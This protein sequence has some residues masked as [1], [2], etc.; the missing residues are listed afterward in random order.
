M[1]PLSFGDTLSP[2]PG[3][4]SV[5]YGRA[6]L[7]VSSPLFHVLMLWVLCEFV[8]TLGSKGKSDV[9]VDRVLLYT[10][11]ADLWHKSADTISWLFFFFFWWLQQRRLTLGSEILSLKWICKN[12]KCEMPRKKNHL[13]M[14]LHLMCICFG[15]PSVTWLWLGSMW[16]LWPF[17]TPAEGCC[18]QLCGRLSVSHWGP[19][20]KWWAW[21][22]C[23]DC[24]T[25]YV[26]KYHKNV[27]NLS[28]ISRLRWV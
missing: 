9:S 20:F 25:Q 24:Y 21:R 27:T 5:H 15:S 22:W 1:N 4:L 10:Q 19:V 6:V 8:V 2:S 23:Q 11:T 18:D 12:V 7:G 28:P 14:I 13:F 26:Q 17:L 16:C 3:G